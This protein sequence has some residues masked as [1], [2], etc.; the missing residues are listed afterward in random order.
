MILPSNVVGEY[1]DFANR[2][3]SFVA[4]TYHFETG[5][6]SDNQEQLWDKYFDLLNSY[7][8]D[9]NIHIIDESLKQRMSSKM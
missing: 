6:I 9:L 5:I 1:Y 4:S 2:C 7:R 3:I 8:E